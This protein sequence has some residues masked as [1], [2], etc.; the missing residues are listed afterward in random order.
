MDFTP[1]ELT[2]YARHF[3]LAE[4]G[5]DGQARLRDA[6]VLLVGAGGLGSPAV[7]YLAA[8]GVGTLGIVDPD[9]VDLSNL[10]R[11][12]VHGTPSVGRRKTDSARDRLEALNP[13]VRVETHPV[14]LSSENAIA[15]IGEYDIVLD[16]SDNFPTRYLV[17]DACGLLGK[18]WIY[19][20]ILR[21]EG[22][23]SLFGAPGGP[24]YR[25]LFREPPPPGAVPGC[26]EAGVVGALPGV[27]GSLQALEAV[28]WILGVGEGLAGRLLLFD[29]LAL[30]FREI[31]V[32]PDPECALCGE[33]P[34][35]T[36]LIDYE[37]FCGEVGEEVEEDPA[38]GARIGEGAISPTE[39]AG[40]LEAGGGGGPLV[41]DVRE[42][43][44]W[45]VDNLASRGAILIP[46]QG[47]LSGATRPPEGRDLV[48]CCRSGARS[49]V[50]VRY[51]REQGF[52]S[53][54]NLEGGLERWR[55][56]VDEGFRV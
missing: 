20:A 34:S 36:E 30:E 2:R 11:Q 44:E 40:R 33:S 37:F 31:R 39:L 15:I 16:G 49:A 18:P 23:V 28:K 17:N 55:D 14:R 35:L 6:R 22:Q 9:R 52:A 29:A 38:S 1:D 21:W 19:G 41:V 24:C 13:E 8:A 47:L 56:E 27:I 42:R 54:R 4:M 32:R 51:L 46:L 43:W 26:A 50:A 25:C 45:E 12:V 48:V 5:V 3:S 10:Q 53:A 7:L